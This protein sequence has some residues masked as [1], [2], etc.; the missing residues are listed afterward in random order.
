MDYYTFIKT[1]AVNGRG[2]KTRGNQTMQEFA[3]GT[4]FKTRGKFPKLCTVKDILRTY[5]SANELVSIRYVATHEFSG[6]TVIDNSVV[7]TTI[8]MGLVKGG[9]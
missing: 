3:I 6:Q 5:N 8:A 1:T 7:A 2:T 9:A 4:K